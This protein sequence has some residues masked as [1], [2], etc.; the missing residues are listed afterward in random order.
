MA[1]DPFQIYYFQTIHV[2]DIQPAPTTSLERVRLNPEVTVLQLPPPTL[3][4]G[5]S[6]QSESIAWG[7][8]FPW[9]AYH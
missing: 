7:S 9:I 5:N 2:V 4:N 8:C 3:R 1:D 6:Q